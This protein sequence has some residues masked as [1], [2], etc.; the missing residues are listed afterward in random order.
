[1]AWLV[2]NWWRNAH[3]PAELITETICLENIFSNYMQESFVQVYYLKFYIG[4]CRS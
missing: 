4:N 2:D 3:H 1:M